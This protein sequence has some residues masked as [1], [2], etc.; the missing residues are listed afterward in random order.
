MDSARILRRAG[1]RLAFALAVTAVF[2]FATP[3][4]A[5]TYGDVDSAHMYVGAMI[6]DY[7]GYGITEW[8]TGTLVSSRVFL[9]AGHC[10]FDLADIGITVDE[11]WVSFAVDVYA[12]GAKWYT[13]SSVI[14]HP[15]FYWGPTSDPHDVAALVLSKPVK[16]VG[17]GRIAP[18]GYLD[19]LDD[20]GVLADAT[21]INV[22]YG[23][24]Q[25]FRGDGVRRIS[26]SSFLSLHKA[27]LYMSQNVHS[28]SAG[29][30]FGDS[31]GPT[32]YDDRGTEYVVAIVSWGDAMCVATNINYRMDIPASQSF[33]YAVIA[34]YG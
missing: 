31:G 8:C 21:F 13:V 29:T 34:A 18:L 14:T 19:A 7:P 24:D 10:T 32:L 1:V 26:Y 22:G 16:G 4:G 12:K 5:I 11:V 30:C 6:V 17:L 3:A 28:G 33:I 20:A 2:A 9:T 27:W 23:V 25:D 15:D